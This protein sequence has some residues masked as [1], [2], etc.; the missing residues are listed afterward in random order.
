MPTKQT[1]AKLCVLKEQQD[2][3]LITFSAFI[4]ASHATVKLVSVLTP[5]ALS[6]ERIG[7]STA[8]GVGEDYSYPMAGSGQG[9]GEAR[10]GGT[11]PHGGFDSPSR[12]NEV[13]SRSPSTPQWG[14]HLKTSSDETK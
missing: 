3:R 2:V 8:S 6:S 9:S 11:G 14:S 1:I 5:T 13:Q 10:C 12:R 4:C 7:N